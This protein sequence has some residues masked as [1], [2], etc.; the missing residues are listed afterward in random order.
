L[1]RPRGAV[2]AD[3]SAALLSFV[4]PPEPVAV[5]STATG[6]SVGLFCSVRDYLPAIA[7]TIDFASPLSWSGSG[8]EPAALAAAAWPSA[9]TT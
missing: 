9:L 2:V 7:S 4:E 5:A 3:I 8:A 1:V 6:P